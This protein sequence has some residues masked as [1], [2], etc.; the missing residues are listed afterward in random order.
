MW[1]KMARAQIII[2]VDQPADVAAFDAW[3]AGNESRLSFFSGNIGCG[4][5]VDIYDVEGPEDVIRTIPQAI[6][7]WSPDEGAR[8]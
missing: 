7:A 3:L 8:G 1:Q 2:A 4:C 5:C 6:L